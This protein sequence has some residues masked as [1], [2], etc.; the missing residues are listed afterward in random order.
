MKKCTKCGETKPRTDFNNSSS[1][2]CKDGK[3]FWCRVCAAAANK[4]WRDRN[5]E[6]LNA[7][8]R[9][10]YAKNPER[11]LK[12]M[13]DRYWRDPEARRAATAEWRDKNPEKRKVMSR[14]WYLN[15]VEHAKAVTKARYFANRDELLV[16]SRERSKEHYQK[17]KDQYYLRSAARRARKLGAGGNLTR[18]IRKRLFAS[19]NGR[20]VYCGVVLGTSPHLDHIVPLVRGGAH[21]DDNVQLL[22][23]PCNL[24]KGAK[25]PDE[26]LK[27]RDELLAMGI[28][29]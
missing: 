2:K 11:T 9:A 27:Y 6:K 13:H 28:T 15:N 5:A 10:E 16:Y 26:F 23:K 3:F 1:K 25:M 21:S 19:Q 4:A 8:R 14:T 17:N 20:C 29:P 24:S 18:G 12:T 22:C 7:K